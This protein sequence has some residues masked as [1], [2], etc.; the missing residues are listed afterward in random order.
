MAFL[1]CFFFFFY[2]SLTSRIIFKFVAID[3]PNNC[4][5]NLELTILL[6]KSKNMVF[7]FSKCLK[8]EKPP[9]SLCL[10]CS[11]IVPKLRSSFVSS[12]RRSS[13]SYTRA[14]KRFQIVK[15]IQIIV[16]TSSLRCAEAVGSFGVISAK[17]QVHLWRS[18]I[19]GIF[20]FTSTCANLKKEKNNF[21]ASSWIVFFFFL[22]FLKPTCVN[23]LQHDLA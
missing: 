21:M 19:L 10:Y 8:K 23:I 1:F 3:S 14:W 18:G 6:Y 9:C 22:C 16:S 12:L 13:W 15:K 20:F 11:F 4:S 17:V 7:V 2:L 5:T